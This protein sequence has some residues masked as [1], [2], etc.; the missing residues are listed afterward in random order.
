MNYQRSGFDCEFVEELPRAVQNKCPICLLVL[1]EPYQAICCGYSF[2]RT[3]IEQVSA[4]HKSCPCCKEEGFAIYPNKGLQR[5]VYEFTVYCF[6]KDQGCQ[7]VGELGHLDNHLNLNPSQQNQL[8]GCQYS[9][10][11]CLHCSKLYLRLKIKDHQ[12][13]QCPRRPFSCEYCKKFDSCYEDVA[14]N[15]W[16]VCVN[17]PVPCK[18]GDSPQ[19]QKL[20]SH[21]ANDC[22]LT[23]VVCDFRHVGCEVRL[24]RK[25]MPAHYSKNLVCHVSLLTTSH[26]RLEERNGRLHEEIVEVK[27]SVL[28]L[29]EENRHLKEQIAAISQ[30]IG[31]LEEFL[32]RQLSELEEKIRRLTVTSTP[33]C[34]DFVMRDYAQHKIDNSDWVSPPFYSHPHGY[35]L[36]LLVDANGTGKGSHVSV[37]LCNIEGEYDGGLFWPFRGSLAVT[38]IGPSKEKTKTIVCNRESAIDRQTNATVYKTIY[39]IPKFFSH[40]SLHR[41]LMDDK[42]HLKISLISVNMPK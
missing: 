8:Q 20:N 9:K 3:C 33:S 34:M 25:D 21:I 24:P 39:G 12:N 14:T 4:K 26:Q 18:C 42:L 28:P 15:H 16:P 27:R 36:C 7:W 6:N 23:I 22:P 5:A 40:S 17:Y 35:K 31:P 1:R 10:V 38:V 19:R 30:H 2:C 37:Y 41:Y 11:K 29:E 32:R 13:R